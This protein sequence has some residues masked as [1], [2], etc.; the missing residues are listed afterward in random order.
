MTD[1]AHA[2][3]I[4]RS[5]HDC[6]TTGDLEQAMSHVADDVVCEAPGGTIVGKVAYRAFLEGFMS[7]LTGVR[8]IAAFGDS[9]T[10]VLV[11]YPH[12]AAT[13]A[14]PAAE[15]F[16][17]VAGRVSRSALVF[18]RMSFAPPSATAEARP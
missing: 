13:S 3:S 10:A 6:W 9:D 16:V 12:T 18:D 14:A 1:T 7:Q 8:M 2:L 4:A 5:Y 15:H 11:Y 17:V